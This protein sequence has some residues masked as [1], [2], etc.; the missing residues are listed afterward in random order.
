[1]FSLETS[2][3]L[4][5]SF[6]SVGRTVFIHKRDRNSRN[7][8]HPRMK[9]IEIGYDRYD[10][11][12][13]WSVPDGFADQMS[14]NNVKTGTV[15]TYENRRCR[16]PRNRGRDVSCVLIIVLHARRNRTRPDESHITV[17][18]SEQPF[19]A[20]RLAG[21]RVRSPNVF[22]SRENWSVAEREKSYHASRSVLV[23]YF[24]T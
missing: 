17:P 23:F 24:P 10:N 2:A 22:V 18:S 8:F 19:P 6:P 16:C 13:C 4:L 9:S 3:I 5:A 12:N 7:G 15:G 11:R 14:A 20:R 1:M 21:N